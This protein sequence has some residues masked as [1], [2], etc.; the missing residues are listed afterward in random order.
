M[1]ITKTNPMPR[2]PKLKC[3]ARTWE[4]S[5]S[6]L[7]GV[8]S[9]ANLTLPPPA[10]P[11]GIAAVTIG[12]EIICGASTAEELVTLLE[13]A[14]PQEEDPEIEKTV[15]EETEEEA[16]LEV[17]ETDQ[18]QDQDPEIEIEIE[19]D[20]QEDT[21]MTLENIEE[22]TT[23]IETIAEIEIEIGVET[24]IDREITTAEIE[25]GRDLEDLAQ[26]HIHVLQLPQDERGD[27][28][29]EIQHPPKSL[30][31][32]EETMGDERGTHLLIEMKRTAH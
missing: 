27:I 12:I 15:T 8:K 9:P 30:K 17:E 32:L 3:K 14:N 5:A 2:R 26:S 10:S 13:S 24:V 16:D 28:E 29:A 20:H 18:D 22:D 1:L 23:G 11:E 4:A 6:T 31:V 21:G 19:I 7:N 25:E